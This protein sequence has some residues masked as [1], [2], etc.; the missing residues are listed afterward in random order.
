MTTV[1][2]RVGSA[3]LLEFLLI[4]AMASVAY[5]Q[6]FVPLT[7]IGGLRSMTGRYVPSVEVTLDYRTVLKDPHTD[8]F[9]FP[10]LS[11]NGPITPGNG[12]EFLLPTRTKVSVWE[13]D[14]RQRIGVIGTPTLRGLLAIAILV[15]L[16]LMVR[17]LRSGD[18]FVPAN[19][20]R[21]YA[22]AASVG[23]G[24]L[25]ADLLGQWGRHGVLEHPIVA[26]L[27]IR[28]SYHLSLMPLAI[29]VAIAV[30]AEVFRQGT[31]LRADVDGLV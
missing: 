10:E 4:V 13:P 9:R 22:I 6:V 17:T 3:V 8:P 5:S 24:G 12:L 15:L 20:R 27:V 21:M 1:R 26:P 23:L 14:F 30:A 2:K 28:E 25:L 29:G 16:L 11:T 19:A 31:L 7:S 18:P